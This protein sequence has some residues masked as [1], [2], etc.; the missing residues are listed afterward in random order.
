[1]PIYH[2]RDFSTGT[3]VKYFEDKATDAL[4][5]A[6]YNYPGSDFR[7]IDVDYT[8]SV[9]PS[10]KAKKMAYRSRSRRRKSR[11]KTA[12]KVVTIRIVTGKAK[13]KRRRKA[14]KSRS[15]L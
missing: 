7:V 13:S 2:L 8:P 4:S 14:R 1:M 11:R 3:T 6:R 9:N 10:K 15:W 5:R 12:G